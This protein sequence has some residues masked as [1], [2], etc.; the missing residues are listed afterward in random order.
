MWLEPRDLRAAAGRGRRNLD[1][2]ESV[3]AEERSGPDVD[4]LDAGVRNDLPAPPQPAAG[5][6]EAKLGHLVAEVPV[7]VPRPQPDQDERAREHARGAGDAYDPGRRA[8]VQYDER[9]HRR[10]DGEAEE[11]GSDRPF[12]GPHGSH[13]PVQFLGGL[14]EDHGESVRPDERKD[15]ARRGVDDDVGSVHELRLALT[16]A[17]YEASVAFYRDALG[18]E[19]LE[20]WESEDGHGTLLEAG[21]ATIE[22]IDERHA[23]AVDGIEVGRRVAGPIRVALEVDDSAESA[24]R[25]RERGAEALGG[26]VETPWRHRNVRLRAP[27]GLQLTLFTVLDE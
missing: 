1:G 24:E 26:P 9:D 22:L 8:G 18:L 23:Q 20:I 11:R 13:A 14:A 17:D 15:S 21:Q 6:V 7:V 2:D 16:V 10:S 5:D 27:D 4:R 3:R 19:E 25:L 12:E